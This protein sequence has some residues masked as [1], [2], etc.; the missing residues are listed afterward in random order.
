MIKKYRLRN[1]SMGTREVALAEAIAHW[2]AVRQKADA[3]IDVLFH[4]WKR[5]VTRRIGHRSR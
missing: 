2:A 4:E 3:K 1:G 5:L